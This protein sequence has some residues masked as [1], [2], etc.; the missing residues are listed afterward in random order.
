[1]RSLAA[2]LILLLWTG[3]GF[4]PEKVSFYDP[5][6]VPLISA[7]SKV[8]RTSFGF[9]R[10]AQ[11]SDIRLEGGSAG[12]DAM[13][14]VYA[15]TRR[16]IAFRKT[17]GGYRWIGEQEIFSGP[18]KYQTV[19]GEATEELCIT[20]HLEHVQPEAT[21]VPLHEVHIS[22]HG[23]DSRFAWPKKV[24]LKEAQALIAEWT[25]RPN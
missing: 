22:Y 23:L 13:L 6:L 5:R 25:K 14:H 17:P 24:T 10:I 16:T 4:G 11:N 2:L 21:G 9:T 19:D 12:Y 1:M 7:I 20:Y 18:G 8:D 15:L 3:C